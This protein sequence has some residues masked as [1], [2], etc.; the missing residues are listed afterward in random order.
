MIITYRLVDF[1]L[2]QIHLLQDA[3]GIPGRSGWFEGGG[4]NARDDAGDVMIDL[5]RLSPDRTWRRG[6][7]DREGMMAGTRTFAD[8]MQ[9]GTVAIQSAE[10]CFPDAVARPDATGLHE[11]VLFRGMKAGRFELRA[12]FLQEWFKSE[13]K[14]S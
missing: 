8:D 1:A 5:T 12:E 7:V 4:G 11:D 2:S 3:D 6:H 14:R 9:E 13:A 10:Q